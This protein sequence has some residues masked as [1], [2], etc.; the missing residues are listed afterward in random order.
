MLPSCRTESN[1]ERMA[2]FDKSTRCCSFRFAI[3]VRYKQI[4]VKFTAEE[5]FAFDD[6]GF[7]SQNNAAPPQSESAVWQASALLHK[8]LL[9]ASGRYRAHVHYE[10]NITSRSKAKAKA[11]STSCKSPMIFPSHLTAHNPVLRRWTH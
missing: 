8:D 3:D 5:A 7:R 1:S 2:A 9:V 10:A 4:Y 6:F 11:K